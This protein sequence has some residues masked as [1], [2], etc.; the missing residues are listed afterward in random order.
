MF[1]L[2]KPFIKVTQFFQLS[3]SILLTGQSARDLGGEVEDVDVLVPLVGE[4][5]VLQDG[6]QVAHLRRVRPGQRS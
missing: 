4:H 1:R 2:K 5:L 6:Q 3:D